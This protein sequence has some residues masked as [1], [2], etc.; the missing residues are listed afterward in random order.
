MGS[1]LE[2][3][4]AFFPDT[5]CLAADGSL[6]VGGCRLTDLAS[7]FGTPVYV[8]DEQARRYRRGLESRRPGSRVAFPSESPAV[9][10]C[11][12]GVARAMVRRDTDEDLLARELPWP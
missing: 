2:Q 11:R 3:L 6:A 4:L 8:V 7:E 9:V 5:T 1:D 12:A 10:F